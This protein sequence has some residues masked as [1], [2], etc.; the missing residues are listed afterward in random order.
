MSDLIA[1]FMWWLIVQILGW[2]AWPV[3]TRWLRWLPDRGYMLAKPLGLLFV[4]YGL[5]LLASVGLIQNTTGGIIVVLIGV[6]ALSLWGW[7]SEKTDRVELFRLWR[8]QRWLFIAYEIVF[9]VAL[10]SWA[11]F[12]AHAPDLST[13]EK[14]MEFAFF[15]AIN[16]SATFPPL[17]PWLSGYAIAYYYFGYV[18][19]S[20]LHQLTGVAAGVAFSLSNAFWFALAAASAFGVVGNLVLVFKREAKTAAIVFATLGAVMLTVMG[21]F[22]GPLEVAHAN[23][24]GSAEFWQ[25]LDILE[26]NGPAVQNPPEM[27]WWMP[28]GGWWWWRSSRVIHDYPP[29]QVS[30]LLAQITRLPAADRSVSQEVIDEF[31]QFSYTLGDM[32]PHV[33]A[34]PF[35]LVMMALALNLYQGAARGE[36]TSLWRGA[37]RAPLWPL[38]AL[39]VGSLGFLNTWD[40]PIYAFVLAMALG[41]G[42]WRAHKPRVWEAAIDLVLLGAIGV[43]LYLPFYRGF[44]SQAGG[45]APNLYNGTRFPQFF[46]MFGPYLIIGLMFGL[47]LIYQA[48]RGKQIRGLPFVGKAIGGGIGVAALLALLA[49]VLGFGMTLISERARVALENVTAVMAQSGLSITDHLMARLLSPWTPLLIG[50]A[51]AAIVLLW[52]A[53]RMPSAIEADA[54]RDPASPIDFVLLLFGVGLLLTIGT[55]FFYLVD[56]FGTRMNTV[57]KFYYQAW[58]LWAVASAFAAYYLISGGQLNRI[59]RGTAAVIVVLV[60]ALGLFFPAMVIPTMSASTSEP[61]LDALAF[62][63]RFYPDDYAAAQWLL[64]NG[65]DNPVIL[66]TPGEQYHPEM[67]RLSAWTGLPSVVGWSGHEGQWRGNYDIQGPRAAQIEE[68]YTTGDVNRMLELLRALNVGYVVVGPNEQQRYPPRGLAKFEQYLPVAFQQGRV[69]IYRVP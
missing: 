55:E 51:L 69:T 22:Q 60:V 63:G 42:Y 6:A 17:D 13:T 56:G 68:I 43:A 30:P 27:P 40:F 66:E 5:W 15:N 16:R 3:L 14:P 24:V 23:N 47:V 44:T 46:V 32:H 57:F 49:G 20:L 67:S 28:R 4:A 12:R 50:I 38:Y 2:A 64:A 34:L 39:A 31:P 25:W 19:M 61:T 53:R 9:A 8:E 52:I 36:I 7:R 35:A 59:V 11:I 33:L 48:A 65:Q 1:V 21:N 45:I 54:S 41:L 58:A 29:E 26:I 62:T 37:R 10:I 18:M